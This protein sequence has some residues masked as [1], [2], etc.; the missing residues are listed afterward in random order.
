VDAAVNKRNT[1]CMDA[2]ENAGV[3][4]QLEEDEMKRVWRLQLPN[5]TFLAY[6]CKTLLEAQ[7]QAALRAKKHGE[8]TVIFESVQV[9]SP[10]YPIFKNVI[11]P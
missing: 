11:A 2:S 9:V 1:R 5:G 8:E 10:G 4:F 7:E 3:T 6:E